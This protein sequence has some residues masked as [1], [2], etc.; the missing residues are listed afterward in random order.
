MGRSNQTKHSN[1]SLTETQEQLQAKEQR[2]AELDQLRTQLETT[3]EGWKE[4]VGNS[5]QRLSVAEAEVQSLRE[6]LTAGRAK[7]NAAT[8]QAEELK[9]MRSLMEA[10]EEEITRYAAELNSQGQKLANLHANLVDREMAFDNL[11]Q[12]HTSRTEE[13]A[14]VK[15]VAGERIKGLNDE[16]SQARQQLKEVAAWMERRRRQE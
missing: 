5:L 4:N 11:R 2:I 14:R 10:K 16:L 9:L 1:R 3:S 6:Q 8:K 15:R 12:E 13:L 7:V